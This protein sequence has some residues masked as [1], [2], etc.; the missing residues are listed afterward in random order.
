[1][2]AAHRL[3]SDCAS[4]PLV[5]AIEKGPCGIND[6]AE[7]ASPGPRPT[8][9]QHVNQDVES[10]LGTASFEICLGSTTRYAMEK[11]SA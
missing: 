1:M 7:G 11:M 5:E 3:W 6:T 9:Y 4:I 10:E 8:Q 2:G